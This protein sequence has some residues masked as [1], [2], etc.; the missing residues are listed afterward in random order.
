MVY[1]VPCGCHTLGSELDW[2]SS[3]LPC[4]LLLLPVEVGEMSLTT[5]VVLM[6]GWSCTPVL[7]IVSPTLSEVVGSASSEAAAVSS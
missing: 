5:P 7:D 4:I 1:R 3:V 2:D 6:D